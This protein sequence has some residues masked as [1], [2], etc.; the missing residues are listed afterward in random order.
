M[1]TG[2]RTELVPKYAN[3]RH[4]R[5]M[6]TNKHTS[7]DVFKNVVQE[8]TDINFQVANSDLQAVYFNGVTEAEEE[9]ARIKRLV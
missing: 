2:F 6:K 1:L 4:V 9:I 8:D 5:E 7:K 3:P